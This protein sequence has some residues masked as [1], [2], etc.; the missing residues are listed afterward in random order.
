MYVN[1]QIQTFIK[2]IPLVLKQSVI[3]YFSFRTKIEETCKH[4]KKAKTIENVM[5][6]HFAGTGMEN[7]QRR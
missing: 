2:K 5:R 4:E 7:N 6:G 1:K 3:W